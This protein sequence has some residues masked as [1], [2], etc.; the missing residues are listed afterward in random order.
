M[1]AFQESNS[2]STMTAFFL[3]WV[4]VA[5]NLLSP[6]PVLGGVAIG[7]VGATGRVKA[8]FAIF[9]AVL[10]VIA[11]VVFLRDPSPELGGV[12][13]AVAARF[14]ALLGWAVFVAALILVTCE[15]F[16]RGNK[17]YLDR[18]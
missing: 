6:V 15:T 2:C 1:I 16:L 5:A 9:S 18:I 4:S 12:A 7:A 8:A 17:N 11:A 3:F 10:P 13:Y 14:L